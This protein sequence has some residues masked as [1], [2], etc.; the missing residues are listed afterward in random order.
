MG[1][2]ISVSRYVDAKM[3]PECM[4]YYAGWADKIQGKVTENEGNLTITRHEAIG[5]CAAIVPWNL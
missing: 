5:V 2:A 3:L 4:R 1:K